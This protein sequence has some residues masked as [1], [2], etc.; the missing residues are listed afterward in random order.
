MSTA[1]APA[2]VAMPSI[3]TP[4]AASRARTEASAPGATHTCSVTRLSSA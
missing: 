4:A 2:A 1:S 3:F